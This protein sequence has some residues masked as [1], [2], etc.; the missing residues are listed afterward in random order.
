MMNICEQLKLITILPKKVKY[1]IDITSYFIILTTLHL[2]NIVNNDIP[3]LQSQQ[4]EN[5]DVFLNLMERFDQLAQVIANDLK[6]FERDKNDLQLELSNK[7]KQIDKKSSVRYYYY[8][9]L[10]ILI[11]HHLLC[12]KKQK[13]PSDEKAELFKKALGF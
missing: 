10:Y 1:Y 2:Y 7:K 12:S 9:Y 13:I 5:H 11:I 4:K 6:Q 3:Q 8:Y